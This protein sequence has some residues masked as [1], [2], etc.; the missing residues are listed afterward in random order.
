MK[1]K[2]L[3]LESKVNALT[4]RERII[5]AVAVAVF[6]WILFQLL[7]FDVFAAEMKK[8]MAKTQAYQSEVVTLEQSSAAVLT[9]FR[10]NPNKPVENEIAALFISKTE[11]GFTEQFTVK[12]KQYLK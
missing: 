5:I 8:A 9:S 3:D 6:I 10:D 4:E 1:D 12:F 7:V 11:H 2:L